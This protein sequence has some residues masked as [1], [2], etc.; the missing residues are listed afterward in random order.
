MTD[1]L[2][3]LPDKVVERVVRFVLSSHPC[4][5]ESKVQPGAP[6]LGL[7]GSG[8]VPLQ[9]E[10]KPDATGEGLQRFMESIY[11][12]LRT[13]HIASYL[14]PQAQ[15]PSTLSQLRRRGSQ[16][17]K[18]GSIGTD[19]NEKAAEEV[20]K[21]EKQKLDAEEAAEILADRDVDLVEKV[22]CTIFYNS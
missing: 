2:E 9:L 16:K 5:V 12:D 13:F 4:S 18:S 10:G 17:G 3:G 1:E 15:S 14:S 8:D 21:R 7:S 20:Q 11:D 6:L 19:D 22:V